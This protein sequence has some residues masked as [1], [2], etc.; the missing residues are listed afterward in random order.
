MSY[1]QNRD[2]RTLFGLLPRADDGAEIKLPELVLDTI[3]PI[4]DLGQ[5]LGEGAAASWAAYATTTV[6]NTSIAVA[7]TTQLLSS[8]VPAGNLRLV[9]RCSMSDVR[10]VAIARQVWIERDTPGFV[11][12]T[13]IINV[14]VGVFGGASTGV[15]P[16]VLGPGEQISANVLPALIAGDNLEL[17]FQFITI[18]LTA[19]VPIPPA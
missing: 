13:P 19:P 7:G 12:L 15:R 10:P 11:R 6:S 8:A 16:F 4:V 3:Q 2:L 18:P 5:L 14:P 9:L 17:Q 1:R